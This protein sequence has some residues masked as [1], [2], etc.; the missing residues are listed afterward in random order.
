MQFT[1]QRV[2]LSAFTDFLLQQGLQLLVLQH[3]DLQDVL[4]QLLHEL[5]LQQEVLQQFLLP[6]DERVISLDL[7]Q[8]DCLHDPHVFLQHGLH[9]Q[10]LHELHDLRVISSSAFTDFVLQQGLQLLV[11]QHEDLQDVLQHGLH[12]F[13][14]QEVLQQLL[15]P[16]D[17]RVTSVD[18][19]Q[20]DCLHDPQV[21]LQDGLHEQELHELHDLR[22]ISS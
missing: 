5:F 16:H 22:V 9:E 11:L 10:E 18:L 8:Q 2:S 15:L 12:S 20:Q 17:E 4:Q 13:L 21:C 3:E 1:L 19:L 14:Q 6:H 7:E